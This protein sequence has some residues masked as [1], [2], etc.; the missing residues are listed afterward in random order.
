[1][2]LVNTGWTGGPFGVGQRMELPHT[3]A[4]LKAVLVGDL[5]GVAFA[6][7]PVFGL[8]VPGRCPGVPDRLLQPRNA[9]ADKA[10]YDHTAAK[11]AG[12]FK[13]EVKKY[14]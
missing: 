9:W 11:L 10:A 8:A 14:G 6:P 12:M 1:M 13:D 5:N 3:R 2:W 7:D 4:L